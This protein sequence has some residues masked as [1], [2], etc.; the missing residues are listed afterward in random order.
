MS[1][2]AQEKIDEMKEKVK[3]VQE[4]IRVLQKDILHILNFINTHEEEKRGMK[5]I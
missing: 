4:Q 1:E 3:K 2:I 5:R